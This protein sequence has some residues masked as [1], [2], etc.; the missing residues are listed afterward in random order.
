MQPQEPSA[1]RSWEGW[2]G[3]LTGAVLSYLDRLRS[4]KAAELGEWVGC[5][6]RVFGMGGQEEWRRRHIKENRGD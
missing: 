5:W 6:G 2:R 4:R 3:P 1:S